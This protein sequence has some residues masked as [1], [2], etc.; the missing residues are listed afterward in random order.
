LHAFLS[1]GLYKGAQVCKIIELLFVQGGLSQ[2]QVAS[3]Y[4][5]RNVAIFGQFFQA[6]MIETVLTDSQ[7][8]P[9]LV[10]PSAVRWQK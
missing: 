4:V 1:A 7:L 9:L 3:F 2:K 8:I 10:R 6:G 5:E